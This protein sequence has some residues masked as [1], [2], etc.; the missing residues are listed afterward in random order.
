VLVFR[1]Q[2][3]TAAQAGHL[4]TFGEANTAHLMDLFNTLVNGLDVHQACPFLA[5]QH[6]TQ[7]PP[8]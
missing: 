6:A 7:H 3:Q 1:E 2:L 8:A 5:T 4:N